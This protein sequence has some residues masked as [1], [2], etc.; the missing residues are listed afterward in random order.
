MLYGFQIAEFCITNTAEEIILNKP[1]P[2]LK[3]IICLLL[4]PYLSTL[5]KNHFSLLRVL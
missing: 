3:K 4:I 2:S 1:Q 5:E